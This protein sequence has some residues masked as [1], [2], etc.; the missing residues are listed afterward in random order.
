[1]QKQSRP[2]LLTGLILSIIAYVAIFVAYLLSI[3]TLLGLAG[4]EAL[5]D[6]A[7]ALVIVM[8]ILV[9]IFSLLGLI[10]AAVSISRW[11]LSPQ[12]FA[13]KK[14]LIITTF[15]F[16]VIIAVFLLIGLI[17]TFSALTLILLIVMILA[18]VFIMI[19][20]AKNKKL[21]AETQNVQ[22]SQVAEAKVEE[23]K[24]DK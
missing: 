12:E 4:Q 23:N 15:V 2:F 16:N 14:G 19:D 21:L 5:V 11:K 17:N 20:V 1:M 6:T 8:A 9:M 3:V 18:A 10:F 24:E 7:I 22:S 13:G